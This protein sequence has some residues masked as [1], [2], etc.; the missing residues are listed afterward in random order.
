MGKLRVGRGFSL[1]VTVAAAVGCT[2]QDSDHLT[3]IAGKVA[4]RFDGLG[5]NA[6]DKLSAGWRALHADIDE[7]ALD[8]RVSARLRWEKTLAGSHIQVQANGGIVELKG[9][10]H[11][12]EQR[13][14][15]VE[16]AESTV[17]TEKVSDLLEVPTAEP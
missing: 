9:T 16:V 17:G 1:A 14:R 11:N 12:L 4:A 2:N 13:R 15:A 3:R 7:L 10:V 6:N 8:A 5:D